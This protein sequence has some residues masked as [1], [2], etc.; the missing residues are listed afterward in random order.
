VIINFKDLYCR[1]LKK[2]TTNAVYINLMQGINLILIILL[3]DRSV[4]VNA[5]SLLQSILVSESLDNL[6]YFR[7]QIKV[8]I[9]CRLFPRSGIFNRVSFR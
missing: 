4:N 5:Y 6:Q 2:P 3:L 8:C 7:Y 1:A 9:P